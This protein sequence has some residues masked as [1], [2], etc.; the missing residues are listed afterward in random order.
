LISTAH[1]GITLGDEKGD[2]KVLGFDVKKKI[3]YL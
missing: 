3:K 1:K 2:V